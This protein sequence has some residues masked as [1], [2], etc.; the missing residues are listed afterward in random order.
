MV[1]DTL[2]DA[3]DAVRLRKRLSRVFTSA[4]IIVARRLAR[5]ERMQ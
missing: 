4:T 3:L 1:T 5:L 2:P